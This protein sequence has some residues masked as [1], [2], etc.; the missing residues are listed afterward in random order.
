MGAVLVAGGVAVPLALGAQGYGCS[1]LPAATRALVKGPAAATRALDP[2][3]DMSRYDAERA[4]LAHYLERLTPQGTD[5]D[6]HPE[7]EP[8]EDGLPRALGPDNDLR[9]IA[10]RFGTLMYARADGARHGRIGDLRSFDE[11]ARRH[12]RGAYRAAGGAGGRPAMGSIARRPVS[13]PVRGDL[14]DGRGQMFLTP[15]AW[16]EARTVPAAR[17]A[18]IRQVLDDAY[19]KGYRYGFL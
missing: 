2:R 4:C 14:M 1:Q 12:T 17:A 11:S 16:A 15:D 9:D 7:K 3:D 18:A 13:G 5:Q 10:S 6:Q 8:G 19:V